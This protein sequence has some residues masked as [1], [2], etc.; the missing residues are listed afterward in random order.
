MLSNKDYAWITNSPKNR[1]TTTQALAPHLRRQLSI[2]DIL[3]HFEKYFIGRSDL[4]LTSMRVGMKYAAFGQYVAIAFSFFLSRIHSVI[5]RLLARSQPNHAA[6]I[7]SRCLL[8]FFRE[9]INL[10]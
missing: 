6:V 3:Q 5:W 4:P 8:I 7:R 1:L 2:P 9:A 10:C